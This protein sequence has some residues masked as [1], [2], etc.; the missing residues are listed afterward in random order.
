MGAQLEDTGD[1][2]STSI[3]TFGQSPLYVVLFFTVAGAIDSDYP[4]VAAP[5][6]DCS[7]ITVPHAISREMAAA[8]PGL[9]YCIHLPNTLYELTD[10]PAT[11]MTASQM[12]HL[13]HRI[14]LSPIQIFDQTLLTSG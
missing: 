5:L 11:V 9:W 10:I 7:T 6:N 2:P 14:L 8:L 3:E 12:L 13:N 4:V 1:E